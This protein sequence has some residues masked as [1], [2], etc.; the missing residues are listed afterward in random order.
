VHP[1]SQAKHDQFC[2]IVHPHREP[3]PSLESF[4]SPDTAARPSRTPRW[5]LANRS[6]VDAADLVGTGA[7]G[8]GD[9]VP[10]TRFALGTRLGSPADVVPPVAG[11]LAAAA[12]SQ[13]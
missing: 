13:P 10:G 3:L 11:A 8:S 1:R 4:S 12:A 5:K 2:K 6:L 7:A 9:A